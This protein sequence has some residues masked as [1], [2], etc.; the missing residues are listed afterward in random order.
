MRELS[1]PVAVWTCSAKCTRSSVEAGVSRTPGAEARAP[2]ATCSVPSY[3][4]ASAKARVSAA[5][6][7]FVKPES[8]QM[9]RSTADDSRTTARSA[10]ALCLIRS[11]HG[12]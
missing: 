7:D 2:A 1:W 6:A 12:A 4:L 3:S 11:F 8:S 10:V 9:T 5:R